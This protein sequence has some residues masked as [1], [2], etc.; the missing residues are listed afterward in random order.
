MSKTVVYNSFDFESDHRLVIADIRTLCTKVGR[1]I[2]RTKTP[3]KNTLN[4]N[5]LKQPEVLNVFIANTVSKLETIDLLS[6]ND[7]NEKFVSY[8]NTTTE[9]IILYQPWHNVAY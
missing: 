1:F 8:V 4:V 7:I 6:S 9:E 2:K 5:C 3:K